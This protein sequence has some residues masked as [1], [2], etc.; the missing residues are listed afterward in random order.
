[1]W[2]DDT[3]G[4]NVGE[5]IILGGLH[6]WQDGIREGYVGDRIILKLVM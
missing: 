3:K 5:R 6:R 1:M 4:G 2:Q